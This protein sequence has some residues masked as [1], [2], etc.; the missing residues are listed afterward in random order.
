MTEFYQVVE[1]RDAG[2]KHLKFTRK[3]I[4]RAF[5]RGILQVGDRFHLDGAEYVLK[6]YGELVGPHGRPRRAASK[7]SSPVYHDIR[8]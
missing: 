2:L 1:T 5:E 7:G 6:R 8:S 3:Q 4:A